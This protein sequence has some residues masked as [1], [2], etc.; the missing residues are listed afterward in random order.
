MLNNLLI[1][2][3][4]AVIFV[5]FLIALYRAKKFRASHIGEGKPT[6]DKLLALSRDTLANMVK[7]DSY[8]P[9]LSN[10]DF[11]TSYA[12]KSDI[13]DALVQ[14]MDGKVHAKLQV[15]D[16]IV[17][18]ISPVL[19]DDAD[20]DFIYNFSEPSMMSYNVKF[21][22]ILHF[23]KK[24]YKK[25]ALEKVFQEHDIDRT[26]YVIEDGTKPSY[27]F[28]EDEV[29]EIYSSLEETKNMTRTDKLDIIAR[30]IYQE[31]KGFGIMDTIHEMDI[32]GWMIGTSG[33]TILDDESTRNKMTYH[34]SAW[35]QYRG[36]YIHFR[37][38]EVSD[39]KDIRRIVTLV[40]RF[41]SPGALTQA[42]GKLVNQ[43]ADMSRVAATRPPAADSWA[44]WVR[45][46]SIVRK[47]IWTLMDVKEYTNV[48]L[49]IGW[50]KW[51][52]KA[53][54]TIAVTGRQSSGKTTKMKSL[55]EFTDPRHNMRS[56]EMSFELNNREYHPERNMIGVRETN[57]VSATDM[58]DFLKKTDA[59]IT[60][61]GEVATDEVAGNLV[62]GAKVASLYTIFSHHAVT[63]ED[64][65]YAIRNSLVNAKGY[66]MQ[67]ATDLVL[68]VIEI[69]VHEDFFPDGRR[70]TERIT[71]I[72]VFSES[73]D[74]PMYNKNTPI[75]SINEITREFY[76]RTTD[77]K[78]FTTSNLVEFN[79]RT[80]TYEVA[81][82]PSE[83]LINKIMG[84]L[85]KDEVIE[86]RKFLR[87]WYK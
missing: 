61:V 54:R 47:D 82:V 78:R 35:V 79:K 24:K 30:M 27:A 10:E 12:R 36:K 60:L 83:Q 19:K 29:D 70:F 45:K 13:A 77:R 51:L 2:S 63:T 39:M 43:M 25:K 37:F 64:L 71:E 80:L 84:V 14:C 76:R 40:S 32:D 74:Y 23:Y 33:A 66:E 85:D 55:I 75:D 62:Q 56:L 49:A 67:A 48:E 69:D 9:S 7:D 68:E 38:L 26:K 65:V 52:V 46:F 4:V 58:Q 17:Q 50:I 41:G 72:I 20:I 59:A 3:T 18:I 28:T 16:L 11:E 86:F 53:Q 31:Y 1:I 57:F 81:N 5:L 87:K 15:I 34:K 44:C 73:E 22:T 42:K 6:I 8:D 21:E